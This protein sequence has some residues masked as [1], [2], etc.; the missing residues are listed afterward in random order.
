MPL[1]DSDF[2]KTYDA[3]VAREVAEEVCIE[4]G[5]TDRIVALLNDD[6]NEVGRVHLGIVH[7]WVLDSAQ[8]SRR[9]QM[10]TQMSFMSPAELDAV[11]DTL[12]TWSRVILSEL[13]FS[14][15]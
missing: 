11:R 1:L 6:S 3:A 5:H 12:E 7:C 14:E 9:E 2:R 4:A 13:P 10:I 15:S 8:L